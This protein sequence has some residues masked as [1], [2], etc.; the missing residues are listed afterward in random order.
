MKQEVIPMQEKQGLC[1]LQKREGMQG[2]DICF[3]S[4]KLPMP[5]SYLELPYKYRASDTMHLRCRRSFFSKIKQ[6]VLASIMQR[7]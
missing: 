6:A 4:S 1:D 2:T 3:H 5:I 7:Y